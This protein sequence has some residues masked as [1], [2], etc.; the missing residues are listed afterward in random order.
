MKVLFSLASLK[1]LLDSPLNVVFLLDGTKIETDLS[2]YEIKFDGKTLQGKKK[3]DFLNSFNF[4]SPKLDT[5]ERIYEYIVDVHNKSN[6]S[7]LKDMELKTLPLQLKLKKLISQKEKEIDALS[8]NRLLMLNSLKDGVEAKRRELV[9]T[10]A[11][12]NQFQKLN[13]ELYLSKEKVEKDYLNE[14]MQIKSKYAVIEGEINEQI[15]EKK[16]EISEIQK[17]E[18]QKESQSMKLNILNNANGLDEQTYSFFKRTFF[19]LWASEMVV[20]KLFSMFNIKVNFLFKLKKS[21]KLTPYERLVSTIVLSL[22]SNKEFTFVNID[23]F[24]ILPKERK[25]FY[26]GLLKLKS[27]SFTVFSSL[28]TDMTYL[29]KQNESNFIYKYKTIEIGKL[30]AVRKEPLHPYLK[31]VLSNNVDKDFPILEGGSLIEISPDH[32]VY[33]TSLQR[34]A[35]KRLHRL[36]GD[37]FVQ[38]ETEEKL[39]DEQKMALFAKERAFETIADNSLINKKELV[40]EIVKKE[41]N[42]EKIRKIKNKGEDLAI[43]YLVRKNENGYEVINEDTGECLSEFEYKKDAV[44]YAK[45][46]SIDNL[47]KY[48]IES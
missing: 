3:E 20:D 44:N 10:N 36:Q 32:F 25:A 37:I 17:E 28:I 4:V 35:Y 14:L 34:K 22:V 24:Q 6:D 1:F 23:N 46:L 26:K 30:E 2:K 21:K 8:M 41:V 19:P 15:I 11:D 38:A 40:D 16:R 43:N 13:N 33:A 47:G 7:Y 29:D 48:E 12:F 31:Q 27:S 45:K 5:N 42:L 9:R 39:S 18:Y